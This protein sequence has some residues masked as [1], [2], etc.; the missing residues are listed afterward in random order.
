MTNQISLYCGNINGGI[1]VKLLNGK[2]TYGWK[3]LVSS[4]PS[5]SA[6]G[7]AEAQFT[8]WENPI[9]SLT[10]YIPIDNTPGG[11]MTWSLWN[12]FAKNQYD[13]TSLSMVKL[14]VTVGSSDTAFTSYAEVEGHT[15]KTQIPIQLKS[16]SLNFSP[17][18][19]NN[20]GFWTI[21]AQFQ[22][23]K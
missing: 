23:T 7:N 4:H 14:Y 20:A 12:K 11:F 1:A 10:F 16:Y 17:D 18:D 13:G 22:E 3:N 19:S 5:N 9:I 21:N 15:S 2:F 6:Y 8:G